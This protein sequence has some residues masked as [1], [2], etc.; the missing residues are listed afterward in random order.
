MAGDVAG[1]R[2]LVIDDLIA[3]GG[4][5]VRAA[6]ALAEAGA[7]DV[8]ALAAHG[9]FTGGA[10]ETLADPALA[11]V[12]VTDT[13]PPFRL[14]DDAPLGGRLVVESAAPAMAEAIRRLHEGGSIG[15]LIGIEG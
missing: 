4:T 6:R 3:S 12:T 15:D 10:G 13:V 5:V 9:L 8:H 7:T 11:G 1:A 14:A 2:A